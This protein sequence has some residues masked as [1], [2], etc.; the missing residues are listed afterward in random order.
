MGLQ[1]PEGGPAR[2]LRFNTPTGF[3]RKDGPTLKRQP[4]ASHTYYEARLAICQV[5]CSGMSQSERSPT[6]AP[7]QMNKSVT[8]STLYTKIR[9]NTVEEAKTSAPC[10]QP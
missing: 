6:S 5:S 10:F 9:N 3:C 7:E 2:M 1:T 4:L 8:N